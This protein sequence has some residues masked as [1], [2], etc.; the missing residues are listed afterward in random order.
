MK[1]FS[2]GFDFRTAPL[3]LRAK[4]FSRDPEFI[5]KIAAGISEKVMLSTCNRSEVYALADEDHSS[6]IIDK[7]ASACKLTENEK[8]SFRVLEGRDCLSHL[9]RVVSGMES[10]VVGE[11]QIAGQVKRAYE[12]GIRLGT[13][14]SH[15]HRIFQRA[16]KVAKKVRAQTEVGRLAVSIPSIGV[17]LAESVLGNLVSKKIGIL[18]LGEIGKVSAEYF[19]STQPEKL[20]L[21]NRTRSVAE[22]FERELQKENVNA[23]TVDSP[24]IILREASVIVSAVD[25]VLIRSDDLQKLDRRGVP[26]F[27]LDLS[28]PPSVE[29]FQAADLFL[30]GVD[31]LQKIAQENTALREQE[32][33]KAEKII[34]AEAENCL[35]ALQLS[36]V[37]ETFSRLAAK[38]Q[39]IT[40]DELSH[41][42]MRLGH[43]KREDWLEIEKM[44]SRL[45]SKLVQD[46]MTELKSQIQIAGESESMIQFF[47]NIFRI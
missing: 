21:Y 3:E 33:I 14:G 34:V 25:A 5:Q 29:K 2:I 35:Q 1:V 43:L 11:T 10:M 15:F 8:K 20:Y 39:T 13:V 44:A 18:G 41:L 27:I 36:S 28:V 32:V 30:Y 9:F 40:D 6:A 31:D 16:F 46:P 4:A 45:T 23:E 42:K 38:M 37:S 17:K 12:E 26:L 22:E 24:E 7:W 19:G 47:R